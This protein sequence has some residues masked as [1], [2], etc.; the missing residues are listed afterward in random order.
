[1]RTVVMHAQQRW[2]Y[3]LIERR[4]EA[5]LV[6]E[7]NIL[8]QKGWEAITIMYYKDV[9]GVMAW[10]AFLKRPSGG[11]PT[12]SAEGSAVGSAIRN[13]GSGTA[14]G[15]AIGATSTGTSISSKGTN[16][17]AKKVKVENSPGYEPETDEN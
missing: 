1:M 14:I 13:M 2:E 12:T 8:G 11:Q 6:D 7:L 17:A 9:K 16:T 15:S 3:T 10:T 4:T 5:V